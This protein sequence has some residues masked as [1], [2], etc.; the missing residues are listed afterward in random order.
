M[1]LITAIDVVAAPAA[2]VAAGVD[3]GR[4]AIVGALVIG[5][6]YLAGLA[7]FRRGAPAVC[8]LLMVAAAAALEFSWLKL[9]TVSSPQ[10]L[11]LLEGLFAASVIIFVS[12]VVRAARNNAILGGVMF[13]AAL[14]LVGFSAINLLAGRDAHVAMRTAL[15]G[16]GVFTVVIGVAQFRRDIGARLILPG[17]ILALAA[18]FAANFA[19]AAPALL[20]HALFTLGILGASLVALVDIEP[21]RI[22]DLGLHHGDLSLHEHDMSSPED[23]GRN[24]AASHDEAL[25]VSENQL[26][27]VLDYSG[28]SVWDWC[29]HGAHQTEGLP[30]LV[31]AESRNVFSPDDMRNLI[32]KDDVEAFDRKVLGQGEGGD[33]AF[34]AALKLKDGRPIRLRG[35]RA[36][37]ASGAVERLVA[38]VEKGQEAQKG[39]K[40]AQAGVAAVGLGK[41]AQTALHRNPLET[42]I[43]GALEKGE[44]KAAFQPIVS[45]DNGKI[46]GYEALARWPGTKEGAADRASA[47]ELVQA[48]E[49]AGQGAMLA[50]HMLAAAAKHLADEM[51]AQDRRDLFVAL[52]LSYSQMR[53]GGFVDLFKAAMAAYELPVKSIVLELTESQA[54]PDDDS[55]GAIF[56][57]LKDAGAA[58]AFDD[59]GA[60]FSSLSNLQKYSFD[61][62]KIDKSFIDGLAKGDQGA[63]IVRALAGLGRDLGLTVIAEGIESQATAEAAFKTGCRLGQGFAL[64]VPGTLKTPA[65]VQDK[66]A[67]SDEAALQTADAGDEPTTPTEKKRWRLR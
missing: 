66:A 6:A 37:D 12:S 17:A 19:G 10:L 5:A 36:V 57:K 60:G 30:A 39:L 59:F 4:G 64:G 24:H 52:N 58:L 40:T 45:L 49:A 33:A 1:F 29:P 21:P 25:R 27:Q 43:A 26:A 61:Y 3:L 51:K 46:V 2:G 28:V 11:V 41:A 38:F 18:A 22:A 9:F 53:E 7:V 31:G 48:A 8:A 16:I 34:D 14:I 13:A 35:A 23:Y 55:A 44:I 32:H 62:L 20:P 65:P 42:A 50:R 47:I 54:I 15:V 56:S 67:K 63:Q